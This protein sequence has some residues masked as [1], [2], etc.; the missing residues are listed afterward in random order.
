[1]RGGG[2]AWLPRSRF[3]AHRN[4][5]AQRNV[6][7]TICWSCSAFLLAPKTKRYK[8]E[9]E[10]RLRRRAM[11]CWNEGWYLGNFPVRLTGST[12]RLLLCCDQVYI[13]S[14]LLS[15]IDRVSSD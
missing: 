6:P 2:A 4:T 1:M 11:D 13:I 8:E 15:S 7:E 12:P 5:G 3:V 9:V 14:L 10:F